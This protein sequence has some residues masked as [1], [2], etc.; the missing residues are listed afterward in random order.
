M[1]EPD[2]PYLVGGADDTGAAHRRTVLFSAVGAVLAAALLFAVITRVTSTNATRAGGGADLDGN[3]VAQFDI[4]RAGDFAPTI[5][6]SGPLLFPDPQGRSRDIFVQHLGGSDWR[7]FEARAAGVPRQCVLKW[8]QAARRF[9][10]PCDG[11]IYPPDGAGLVSFPT[12]VN[13]K[14]RVI[15]DLSNP[16]PPTTAPPPEPTTTVLTPS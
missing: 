16:R 6:R 10:D 9:M 12:T 8:D 1:A 13:G 3:R 4:G 5:A 15:V 11:R 7:A 14:G 2:P